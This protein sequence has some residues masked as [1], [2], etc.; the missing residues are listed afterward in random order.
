L[1]YERK[2]WS[3]RVKIVINSDFGGFG[4]SQQAFELL[5]Q[6]KGIEYEIVEETKFGS[7][8]GFYVKGHAGDDNYY[9]SDYD[10]Y[11]NRSDKD[12]VAVVEEL[13]EYANGW[14]ASLKIVEIPDGIEWFIH[15]YDG[16]EHVAE[17]HRTWN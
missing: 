2:V 9:L 4:L 8:K 1:G 16:L 3:E 15:E 7:Y 11:D 17:R 6:R 10:F 12:L 14:A 5:L 13:G